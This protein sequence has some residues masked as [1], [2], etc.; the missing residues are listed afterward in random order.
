MRSLTSGSYNVQRKHNGSWREIAA[1]D[2]PKLVAPGELFRVLWWDPK[3]PKNRKNAPNVDISNRKLSGRSG[4][5]EMQYYDPASLAMEFHIIASHHSSDDLRIIDG[6]PLYMMG[7]PHLFFSA[8]LHYASFGACCPAL[9]REESSVH[10][11]AQVCFI[12]QIEWVLCC[13]F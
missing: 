12:R 11:F 5:Q 9:S 10:T 1:K 3:H 7:E 2:V 6:G 13:N 8:A 4:M